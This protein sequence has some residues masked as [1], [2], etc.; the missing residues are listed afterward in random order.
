MTRIDY[1]AGRINRLKGGPVIE[2][3]GGAD[4]TPERVS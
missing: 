1:N 4:R 2:V 3:G